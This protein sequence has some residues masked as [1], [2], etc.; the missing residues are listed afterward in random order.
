M[1]PLL[2]DGGSQVART[3]VEFTTSTV[4]FCGASGAEK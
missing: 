2:S 3:D 4:K 1:M